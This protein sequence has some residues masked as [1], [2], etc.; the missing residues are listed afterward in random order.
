MPKRPLTTMFRFFKGLSLS[1]TSSTV[2]TASGEV[3]APL[4]AGSFPRRG[5]KASTHLPVV[6]GRKALNKQ[7]RK[8]KPPIDPAA[9]VPHSRMPVSTPSASLT[10][11]ATSDQKPPSEHKHDSPPSPPVAPTS[12]NGEKKDEAKN[13][14]FSIKWGEISIMGLITG[15]IGYVLKT[16]ND[17]FKKQEEEVK[18]LKERHQ[19]FFQGLKM[20]ANPLNIYTKLYVFSPPTSEELEDNRTIQRELVNQQKDVIEQL[21]QIDRFLLGPPPES[22]WTPPYDSMLQG[23]HD[24]YG[25]SLQKTYGNSF[26][27]LKQQLI[28]EQQR[29]G[30]LEHMTKARELHML[31]NYATAIAELGKAQVLLDNGKDD[32]FAKGIAFQQ[33]PDDLYVLLHNQQAKIQAAQGDKTGSLNSYQDALKRARDPS[34]RARL[35][36]NQGSLLIDMASNAKRDRNETEMTKRVKEGVD[37]HEKALQLNPHDLQLQCEYAWGLRVQ[38]QID[39]IC[40]PEKATTPEFQNRREI[41]K[42]YLIDILKL[43]A[44]Q[45]KEGKP[46]SP[47]PLQPLLFLG[48]L[49]LDE[50]NH[51]EALKQIN[52]A[53][54]I[55][56]RHQDALRRQ[57]EALECLGHPT[58][59]NAVRQKAKAYLNEQHAVHAHWLGIIKGQEEKGVSVASIAKPVSVSAS[60]KEAKNVEK[61]AQTDFFSKPG[62]VAA[63]TSNEVKSEPSKP[64]G[65]P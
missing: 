22:R 33:A 7:F 30:W 21:A 65:A 5:L 46:L 58:E 32:A 62:I 34:L 38:L 55:N 1:R 39:R 17:S 2:S 40:F 19:K 43:Q 9:S 45:K 54:E 52:F 47:N 28:E 49:Y 3:S 60:G 41:A 29:L 61:Q 23:A 31:R 12:G 48:V 4:A 59:A 16:L 8:K 37:S 50:G 42:G 24:V 57:A 10:T 36:S 51:A 56:P 35:L 64:G 13:G 27:T 63:T 15:S 44:Q 25:I 18:K 53:L 26:E 6:S 14:K 20:S 11:K